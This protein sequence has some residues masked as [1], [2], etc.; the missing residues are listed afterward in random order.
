ME[1][2]K[3]TVTVR[4]LDFSIC[5]HIVDM[6]VPHSLVGVSAGAI[7]PLPY[8]VQV[9]ILENLEKKMAGTKMA[10]NLSIKIKPTPKT[11]PYSLAIA[12]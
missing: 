5:A 4:Y 11:N 8:R 1:I 3:M 6:L 2:K 12:L 10:G 7:P 9:H